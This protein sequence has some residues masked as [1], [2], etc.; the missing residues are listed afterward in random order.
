MK[1]NK[2]QSPKELASLRARLKQ[3]YDPN[4]MVITLCTGTGCLACGCAP[5]AEAFR[6]AIAEDRFG[7]HRRTRNYRLSWFL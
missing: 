5:V 2:L 3:E 4:K 6:K 1:V 7:R